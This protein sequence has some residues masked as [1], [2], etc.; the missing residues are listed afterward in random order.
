MKEPWITVFTGNS[1]PRYAVKV[2]SDTV[3]ANDGDVCI[4]Y[5]TYDILKS[6]PSP[7]CLDIGADQCWWS[8]FCCQH[9]PKTVVD[10]FEP[11]ELSPVFTTSIQE[12]YPKLHIH[13]VAVSD[14]SGVLP[15]TNLGSDSH[16]RAASTESVPCIPLL[17]FL[18]S[19]PKVDLIKLDTE[20]HEIRILKH[21]LP[22]V[23]RVGALIFECSMIWYGESR[24]E[25]IRAAMDVFVELR[26]TH[27]YLYHLSRRGEPVLH[28]LSDEEV[29]L[30]TLSLCYDLREQF[31]C[32][33]IQHPFT[34]QTTFS[35][36]TPLNP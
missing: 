10:A 23:H 32:L 20:G 4:S 1:D 35:S 3:T 22:A 13:P 25:A 9:F 19:H 17:S 31:D 36:D 12:R 30:E 7:Y 16:S 14:T 33:A 5:V 28:N 8:R 29:L 2:D 6:I 24:I 26:E 18:Q 34:L 15:F 21:I 27:P 11:K